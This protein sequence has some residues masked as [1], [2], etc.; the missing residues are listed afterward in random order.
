MLTEFSS[1]VLTEFSSVV[2]SCFTLSH[3]AS[4]VRLFQPTVHGNSLII[5]VIL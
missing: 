5:I 4:L 1:A 2:R 3:G